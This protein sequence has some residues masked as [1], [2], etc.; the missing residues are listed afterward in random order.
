V[1][2]IQDFEM[3]FIALQR[4]FSTI[5]G[6][7]IL[8]VDDHLDEGESKR[9]TRARILKEYDVIGELWVSAS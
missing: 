1:Q 3:T 8:V 2:L 9:Q 5:G 4:G 7:R 6:L